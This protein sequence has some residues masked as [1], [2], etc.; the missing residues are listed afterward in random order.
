MMKVDLEI[1]GSILAMMRIYQEM[2]VRR[3]FQDPIADM[4][5]ARLS[6]I[7][8]FKNGKDLYFE[9]NTSTKQDTNIK[10]LE[11][12]ANANEKITLAKNSNNPVVSTHK[13]ASDILNDQNLINQAFFVDSN[14]ILESG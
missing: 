10:Q 9:A 11:F 13:I 8:D 4:F 6:T 1:S 14:F 2:K 12:W 3:S 5:W 7:F